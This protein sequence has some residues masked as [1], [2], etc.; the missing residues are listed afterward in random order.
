MSIQLTYN[1]EFS[2]GLKRLIIEE[3][4]TAIRYLGEADSKEGKHKAVHEVRKAFKK[5]R[6]CLR[7]VRDNIDYYKEE[8]VWF[9]DWA[10]Q[11]SD[12]RDATANIEILDALEKQYNSELYENA[13]DKLRKKL[14][15]QRKEYAKEVFNNDKRIKKLH[16]AV[17]EKIEVIPG[18]PLHIQSFDD[19]R[20][21]IKRTYKRGYKGIQKAGETGEVKDFHE[22]RKRAKYLRY[23]IDV[24]NR[25]WPQV[26]EVYEDELHDITDFT[27]TINDL[28]NL[29]RTINDLDEPFESR[30]EKMLFD[31]IK[32]NHE[33]VMKKHSLLKGRKFYFDTPT[34][35]CDRME[36]YWE[37]HQ[38][39]IQREN[40]PHSALLEST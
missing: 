7:L 5:I 35:F 11:I 17:K 9:R 10:R 32:K 29:Q 15:L 21:S 13:F 16:Q 28:N 34:T 40:L 33:D 18:W 25:L 37:T 38:E 1:E 6:A 26:L 4:K 12:I 14:I 2:K 30:E 22:W 36:V 39:V 24:L 31:A 3:C 20:P 23:Q 27:G 19:I 8:N